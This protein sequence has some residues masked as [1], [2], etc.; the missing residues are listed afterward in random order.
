MPTR[1]L[2][3][4]IPGTIAELSQLGIPATLTA[5]LDAL[6]LVIAPSLESALGPEQAP[7]WPAPERGPRS[8]LLGRFTLRRELGRGGMG[9]VVEARDPELRRSVAVKMLI[10][11]RAV[12]DRALRRFVAEAQITSQLE[13]P[14]IVPVYE[15]GVDP[16]GQ[17]FFVMK[18]VDGHSLSEVFQ[19][20]RAQ[21]PEAARTW[22]RHRLLTSFI[23][24][25]NAVAYAHDRG[26]LH[27][28]LKPSNVMLGPFGQVLVMDWGV[29]GLVGVD[30]QPIEAEPMEPGGADDAAVGEGIDRMTMARTVDGAALGTPG[31]M[32]PEQAQGRIATL[33][34][35]S[36]VWSL[37]AI[38][39]EILTLERAYSGTSVYAIMFAS[40]GMPEDPRVR[41]P[42][43]RIPDEIADV[44]LR[45]MAVEADDRYGS[46]TE[47]AEAAE[48]FL[49][50]SERRRLAEEDI[51]RAEEHWARYGALTEEQR[52][53][54]A[55]RRDLSRSLEP[56]AP[57][58]EKAPL[59]AVQDRLAALGL[60]RSGAFEAVISAGEQALSRDP[61]CPAARAVLARAYRARFEEGESG[62]DHE[63][64]FYY[65]QR[66]RQYDDG[67]Y[68]ALLAGTGAL[69]LRTDPPGAE[70]HCER[71]EQRGL[72]WERVEGRSLGSTPL[73]GLPLEMGSYLLTLRAPGRRDTRYPVFISR[74]RHWDS[75]PT[76]VP[77]LTEAEIGEDFVYVPAG[78]FL[79][80]GDH[81]SEGCRPLSQQ[82]CEGFLIRVFPQTM[83]EYAGF[84]NALHGSGR[85]EEAWQR[86]P[87]SQSRLKES[88][89]QI[90]ERPGPGRQYVL[91]EVDKDGDPWDAQWPALSICWDD[92]VAFASW[93]SAQTGRPTSLP[94][95]RQW[96]KAARGVDGR[97]HP[98]GERFDPTLCKMRLSRPGRPTPEPVGT[99]PTDLSVYGMRDV[100]GSVRE[101]CGD[102][103]YEGDAARRPVRGG[104]YCTIERTC[105]IPN[106]YGHDRW[107]VYPINGFRLV[108]PLPAKGERAP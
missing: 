27:R 58:D 97:I 48:A 15:M 23:Q 45:A 65:G 90:W 21:E 98:W 78:P 66:V 82:W 80:G 7:A 73:V 108:S 54:Q 17:V 38:L 99:F 19:A 72:V 5:V 35:R 70:V 47:L 62:G 93:Y 79:E 41:A 30:E 40:L 84:I 4:E 86:V 89:G 64:V 28:D 3:T 46:A 92:A 25:C 44:C 57:L 101:W 16:S 8:E 87:R 100:V 29:A 104:A 59:L 55:R 107:S 61:G 60:E 1:D 105:R 56:W 10:D 91:P 95:E 2:S 51:V 102:S 32:S 69:T 52:S 81:R 83:A 36:D 94:L 14:N 34:R 39:Y 49:E 88:G 33:D 9:R 77:L 31:Y 50:G 20:L 43:R 67:R 26:V 53:A 24:V 71:F 42:E 63:A 75:G 76:A 11:P 13:H 96:E 103:E 68:A 12:Q 6:G 106:R 22:T 18:R 37:G 85:A 74:N